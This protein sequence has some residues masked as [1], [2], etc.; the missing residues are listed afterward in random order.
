MS[1]TIDRETGVAVT[2]GSP[3]A[4]LMDSANKSEPTTL[5]EKQGQLYFIIEHQCW[6]FVKV[7]T[8]QFM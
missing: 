2:G 5:E 4:A 3:T 8:D 6:S 1:D 7:K